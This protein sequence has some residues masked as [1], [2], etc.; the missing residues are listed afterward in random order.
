MSIKYKCDIYNNT[1]LKYARG[2][3]SRLLDVKDVIRIDEERGFD[4]TNTT[5]T[6]YQL[7]MQTHSK[8]LDGARG[9]DRCNPSRKS[10]FR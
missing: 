4:G 3:A 1:S 10:A 5:M 6:S 9:V 8:Y 7:G 2:C